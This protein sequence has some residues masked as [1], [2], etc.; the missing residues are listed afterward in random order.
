MIDIDHYFD[1]YIRK[2]GLLPGHVEAI[3]QQYRKNGYLTRNQLCDLTAAVSHGAQHME[4]NDEQE[5]RDATYDAYSTP[6]DTSKIAI[7]C[8]LHGVK[9]PTASYIL[10]ALDPLNHAIVNRQVWTGLYHL[11]YVDRDPASFTPADYATAIDHIRQIADEEACTTAA[12]SYALAAHGDDVRER[13]A[14]PVTP[15]E[16]IPLEPADPAPPTSSA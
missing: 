10:T 7:L 3:G 15:P 2:N 4:R 13:D 6:T 9:T 16:R 11:G 1:A 8:G 5:C 14:Q 12:V